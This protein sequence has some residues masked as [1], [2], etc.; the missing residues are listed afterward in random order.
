M[1]YFHQVEQRLGCYYYHIEYPSYLTDL[2]D[3]YKGYLVGG[4]GPPLLVFRI[5]RENTEPVIILH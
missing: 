5:G 2:Q 1:R 3:I 4:G